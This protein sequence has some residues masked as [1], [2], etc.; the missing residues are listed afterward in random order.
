MASSSQIIKT[1]DALKHT[2]QD[3]AEKGHRGFGCS[4]G[5]LEKLADWGAAPQLLSETLKNIRLDLGDCQRCRL[6]QHRKH[7]VFGSGNPK[8]KLVFV[9]EG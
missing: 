1:I 6:A 2:L 4:A 5:S 9:G 7:I 8:A 3:L